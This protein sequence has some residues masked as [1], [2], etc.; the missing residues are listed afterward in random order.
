MVVD[1]YKDKAQDGVYLLF[2]DQEKAYDRVS[3]RYLWKVLKKLGIPKKIV[4]CLERL[5]READTHIYINGEKSDPFPVRSG[6]GQGDP[7]GCPSYVAALEPLACAIL[8]DT[9]LKGIELGDSVL[10]LLMFADDTV[11]LF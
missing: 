1:T 5:Y 2:L 3:H 6:V 10:K 7:L 11:F 4:C 9:D 8:A